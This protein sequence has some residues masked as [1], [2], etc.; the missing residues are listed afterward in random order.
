MNP[1]QKRIA[2]IGLPILQEVGNFNSIALARQRADNWRFVLNTEASTQ[3]FQYLRQL[4]CDGAIVRILTPAMRREALKARFPLVNI[5][6]WLE[7]PG[8][9]TVRSDWR[10]MGELTAHYLLNKGFKKFGC[11]CFTGGWFAEGRYAAFAKIVQAVGGEILRFKTAAYRPEIGFV[12]SPEERERFKKWV[13]QLPPPAALVLTDDQEAAEFLAACQET[14]LKIPRDIVAMAAFLHNEERPC[15]PPLTGVKADSEREAIEAIQLLEGL[16]AGK[17]PPQDVISIQPLGVVEKEST[18]TLAIQ[19]RHVAEAVEC[20]RARSGEPGSI[21][22]LIAAIPLSRNTLEK[23]FKAVMGETPHDYLV[24]LRIEKARHLLATKPAEPLK[25]IAQAAG[26][27]DRT[28]LNR[29]FHRVH[30]LS[31]KQWQASHSNG[32]GH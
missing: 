14:G 30:R 11:I 2:L 24:R 29:V 26:F 22:T 27:R 12:L 5:S 16:M 25:N 17:E 8:V 20:I 7:H 32:T 15:T 19:D 4:D 18:A 9:P 31:P 10:A 21:A 3:A 13:R 6:S 28:E 1:Q 23:R